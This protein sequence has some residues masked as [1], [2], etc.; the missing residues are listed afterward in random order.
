MDA[1]RWSEGA[2]PGARAALS[3]AARDAWRG[4]GGEGRRGG[5]ERAR[6]ARVLQGVSIAIDGK[7]YF[8]RRTVQKD[9]ESGD[10]R[11]DQHGHRGLALARVALGSGV[12]DELLIRVAKWW[13]SMVEVWRRVLARGVDLTTEK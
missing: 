13:R 3:N 8:S 1:P 4:V 10:V 5:G 7:E 9:A 6:D 12:M 11:Q 2:A